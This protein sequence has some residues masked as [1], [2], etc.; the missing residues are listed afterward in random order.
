MEVLNLISVIIPL[1]NKEKHIIRAIRSVLGQSF[2]NFELIIVNDGSTDNS[3]D[4]ISQIVDDR[5]TI[6]SQRNKGVSSARNTGIKN[7]KYEYV[8]FLDAD[9]EW[10]KNYLKTI[11]RLIK[12]YPEAKVFSTSYEIRGKR[13]KKQYNKKLKKGF[14]GV[15]N[16]FFKYSINNHLLTSSTTTISKNALNE[17][18]WFSE[19]LTRGED[20]KMWITL[21]LNNNIAFSN[22]IGAT[23]Y[24][25]ATNRASVRNEYFYNSFASEAEDFYKSNKNKEKASNYFY[26]YMVKLFY[27]KANYLIK[28]GKK[29]D[30]RKLLWH[31]RN[32]RYYKKRWCILIMITFL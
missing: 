31:Y 28:M 17:E 19:T 9:D 15:I 27:T 13:N 32:T 6:I 14:E 18:V 4:T 24:L 25:T 21:A 11:V 8:A 29:K 7:A 23:Y 2:S 16:D 5:I 26:E 22:T 12:K 20:L 1:Y 10:K 30:A 3:L